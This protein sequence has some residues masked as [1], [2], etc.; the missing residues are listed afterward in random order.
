MTTGPP[1]RIKESCP[2]DFPRVMV[3]GL[4]AV[5]IC[6][7]RE[8]TK[9]HPRGEIEPLHSRRTD[10]GFRNFA[11]NHRLGRACDRSPRIPDVRRYPNLDNRVQETLPSET[12]CVQTCGVHVKVCQ[13]SLVWISRTVSD[14]PC[15]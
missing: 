8:L 11:T 15:R 7:S 5:P 2:L 14:L 12:G 10:F 6:Q 4:L 1:A 9:S 13:R 3:A